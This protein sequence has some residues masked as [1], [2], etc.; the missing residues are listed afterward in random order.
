LKVDTIVNAANNSLLGGRV[1]VDG[2]I[3]HVAGKELLARYHALNGCTT[4][5]AKII[6]GYKLPSK[7]ASIQLVLYSLVAYCFFT[8]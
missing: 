8:S 4:G 7:F 5:R 6:K 1:G 3:H 2:A